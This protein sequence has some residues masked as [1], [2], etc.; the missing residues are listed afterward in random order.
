MIAVSIRTKELEETHIVE[1]DPSAEKYSLWFYIKNS[2]DS[3]ELRRSGIL[4]LS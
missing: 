4:L 2:L 1:R 3:Q